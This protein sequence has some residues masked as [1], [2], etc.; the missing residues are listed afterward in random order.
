MC[1]PLIVSGNS[2]YAGTKRINQRAYCRD[3]VYIFFQK[4][5]CPH[6]GK[7][8][9]CKGAGGKKTKYMYYFCDDCKLSYNE[10]E[11]ENSLIDYILDL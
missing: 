3:R 11:I 9:T 10:D 6:C 4:L 7:T 8:M 1:L 5:N 2:Q